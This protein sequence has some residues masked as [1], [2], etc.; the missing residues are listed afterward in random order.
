MEQARERQFAT[1]VFL[2]RRWQT[3]APW[4]RQFVIARKQ[5]GW[6]RRNVARSPWSGQLVRRCSPRGAFRQFRTRFFVKNFLV[7]ERK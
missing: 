2:S 7:R 3:A 1:A 4:S 6:I 5:R